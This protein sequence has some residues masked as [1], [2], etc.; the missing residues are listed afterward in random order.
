MNFIYFLYITIF[1]PLVRLLCPFR[2]TGMKNVPNTGALMICA[3]HTDF[4]DPVIIAAAFGYKRRIYFMAKTELLSLPVVGAIFRSAGVYPVQ[5]DQTDITAVKTSL[6]HL[7]EGQAIMLFPEGTRVTKDESVEVKA[8]AVR[9][10]LKTKSAIL[11]IFLTPGRKLFRF[12]RVIIG[13]PFKQ[14]PPS[15]HNFDPLIDELME[16]IHSLEPVK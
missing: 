13:E 11:P 5:R 1:V 7:R 8:G 15:N 3:N 10:S 6:K 16:N 2:T 14:T 4:M 9:M 12:T